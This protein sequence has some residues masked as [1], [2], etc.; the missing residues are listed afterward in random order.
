MKP[1]AFPAAKAAQWP[2]LLVAHERLELV[3]AQQPAGDRFP[4]REVAFFISTGEALESLGDGRTAFGAL[5]ERLGVG[6][7]LVGMK[8]FGLSDDII[9]ELADVAHERVPRELAMLDFAQA[10]FPFAGQFR[11][12]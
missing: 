10:K 1:F 11:A 3:T 2:D 6:H 12:G 4:N 5:A 8:M 9:R 7:V